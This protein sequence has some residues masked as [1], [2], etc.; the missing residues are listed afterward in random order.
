MVIVR[1]QQI[2]IVKLMLIVWIVIH[3]V[4]NWEK[5]SK[6]LSTDDHHVQMYTMHNDN[7]RKGK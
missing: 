1:V 6:V 2:V 5:F 7:R 3:G 4:W